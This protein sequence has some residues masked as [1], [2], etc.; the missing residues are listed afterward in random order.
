MSSYYTSPP[1]RTYSIAAH[2]HRVKDDMEPKTKEAA[3]GRDILQRT[4]EI[5]CYFHQQNPHLIF[6]IENPRGRMQ[7]ETELFAML[8]QHVKHTVTYCK[9]GFD[10]QKATH[11][12]TNDFDWTP[13]PPCIK[14]NPCE[15]VYE[16][17]PGKT[18]HPRGIQA[19]P[20]QQPIPLLEERYRVPQQLI[21][22]IFATGIA[23]HEIIGS[24]SSSVEHANDEAYAQARND[25]CVVE[26][27]LQKTPEKEFKIR[28][29]QTTATNE[30]KNE[31]CVPAI[32]QTITV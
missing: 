17:Q 6:Y 28:N 4:I 25:R 27:H 1:C 5:I 23:E 29:I 13:R 18:T 12:W 21:N 16:H 14:S 22:E 9:Y 31:R 3:L 30:I 10:Y 20:G 24:A 7:H 15:H 26:Q 2:K 8:P 32:P 19:H 11:I